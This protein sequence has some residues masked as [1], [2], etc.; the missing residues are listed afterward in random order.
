M[1]SFLLRVKLA[2]I[3]PLPVS[4]V[5]VRSQQP[6]SIQLNAAIC[7]PT[8]LFL[9][10]P[11]G[12]ESS[13]T[14]HRTLAWAGVLAFT[15]SCKTWR[16]FSAEL[17]KRMVSASTTCVGVELI[18]NHYW[19]AAILVDDT[20]VQSPIAGRPSSPLLPAAVRYSVPE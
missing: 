6:Q 12:D 19:P 16:S 8:M 7:C 9:C 17:I 14:T 11:K 15:N 20:V 2:I 3:D 18:I 13:G 5:R 1:S 4:E 10:Q